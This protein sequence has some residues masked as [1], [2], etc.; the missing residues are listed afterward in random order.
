MAYATTNP[1]VKVSQGPLT[2][3]NANEPGGTNTIPQIWVYSSADP[4][5]TVQGA[6]YFSNGLTLG[7]K[8]SDIVFVID[9]NLLRFY[10]SFVTATTATAG[11]PTVAGT[12][13]ATINST[14][15]LTAD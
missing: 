3:T 12:G 4:I 2:T 8:V 13:S 1:P 15:T 14:T 9:N 5:A 11:A 10:P 6:G 7:M